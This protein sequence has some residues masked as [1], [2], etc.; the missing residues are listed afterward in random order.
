[1]RTPRITDP[2]KQLLRFGYWRLKSTL[3]GY[4]LAKLRLVQ[5]IEGMVRKAIRG[6]TAVILGHQMYLGANDDLGLSVNGI[7][8]PHETA[9]FRREIR[10]GDTVVDVG[11]NIGYFTLLFARLV[12]PKGRVFAFEP[13][14]TNFEL[15]RKNV[16]L[17]GYRNVTLVPKAVS[18]I[19]GTGQLYLTPHKGDARIFDSHDGRTSVAI[20]TI[21]LDDFFADDPGGLDFI[22]IDI[23]GAEPAALRGMVK[24]LERHRNARVVLEYWPIG[25]KLFGEEPEVFLRSLTD[26]GFRLWN[27]DD[28]RARTFPTTIADLL[29]R[30]PAQEENFFNHTNLLCRRE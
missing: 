7:F 18:D 27:L 14:P 17:N 13:E 11:A 2:W 16:E 4:G 20:E 1:V 30:Y 19:S 29:N 22:K 28:E 21:R 23:Q 9:A 15:L 3:G 5:R 26:S 25:L 8:T 6:D 24:L 12:G 10:E